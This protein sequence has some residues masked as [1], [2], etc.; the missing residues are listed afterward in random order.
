MRLIGEAVTSTLLAQ[1]NVIGLRITL[2][3]YDEVVV[4]RGERVAAP[5]CVVGL[6]GTSSGGKME[7][8]VSV[9]DGSAR[10][11]LELVAPTI[12]LAIDN[13]VAYHDLSQYQAGLERLVDERTLE[14]R[15]AQEAREMFFGNISHEIRTPLSLILLAV[16]DVQR[17]AGA[18]LD[19]RA[20]DGLGAIADASRKLVRLVD[21]LL[22]LAAGQAEKL[23]LA[24]EPTDLTG[25]V[26]HLAAAWRPAAEAAGLAL[27]TQVPQERTYANVDPVAFERIASNLI[28]NAVKYTPRGGAI[29]IELS[30]GLKLRLSIFDTGPGIDSDLSA[31][32]FGRF[33]RA[34]GHDR[35][36]AGT[37]IGLALVK[38][39]VEAHDGTGSAVARPRGGTEF[40]V[41]LPLERVVQPPEAAKVP[42]LQTTHA[43]TTLS[44]L[45]PGTVF[46]PKG[47]SAGTIVIAED[48]PRLAESIASLLCDEYTV[49][50]ALD[51]AAALALVKNHQP[52]LLITDVDMPGMNGIELARRFREATGDR[53]APIII[54]SA[55]IDLG[56]RLAGLE[57]GAV[58]YI[59]K[60]FDPAE[61]R[62]RV[63]SQF[64]MRDLA[65]RLHRAEQLSALGILTSGLAH[66]LRN[67]ANGIVNA[68]TPLMLLLPEELAG[69]ETDIGQLIDAMKSSAEQIGF[70]VRQLLGFR[71]NAELEL[72]PCDLPAVVQR[73]VKLA[74]DALQAVDVRITM[75]VDRRVLCAQPL[76]V[77]VLTNLVENAG[78]AAGRGGWVEIRGTMIGE[79]SGR[80]IALEV[81]DSGPGVPLELRERVFEPFFTT[82]SPGKG[83]G[84]G[85]SVA[86]AIIHRH[87]GTIEIR[88]RDR[89]TSFVIELPAE[90]NLA[91]SPNAV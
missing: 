43:P 89:R 32:L 70:L 45:T 65:L 48:E 30:V 85:L 37:G 66:E 4:E 10:R 27:D 51:G 20:R 40:R 69:P 59:G 74:T 15:K 68:I 8:W 54:L 23:V 71:H 81:S 28:S 24:P 64:R 82:K 72:K 79:A 91:S 34:S 63:A 50:V 87:G 49:V 42:V 26:G 25:L 75:D 16:A 78:H 83:T 9:A 47:L 17:R 44:T 52:Q 12:A 2:K 53:L 73:A 29:D 11:M 61:L 36:K 14:L 22:L 18:A 13:A 60:P 80:R 3:A 57:A 38:Q 77:Q 33:E 35:R 55:V 62:A 58:D 6:A 19:D 1:R 86:R 31:R 41:E 7:A 67:P 5:A 88:E 21:E 90:S 46:T 84:L 39:L 56:T 76:L